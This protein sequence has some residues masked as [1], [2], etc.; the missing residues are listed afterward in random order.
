MLFRASV[1]S[2]NLVM[3]QGH[4]TAFYFSGI[5]FNLFI[6]SFFH[7]KCVDTFEW[8]KKEGF[9]KVHMYRTKSAKRWEVASFTGSTGSA[10][11]ESCLLE[12]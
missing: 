6:S 5:I 2:F 11:Y 4:F 10:H 12:L 3:K 9:D 1:P 8:L 7:S